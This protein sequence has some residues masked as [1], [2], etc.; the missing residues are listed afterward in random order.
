MLSPNHWTT[1]EFL[2]IIFK[3][4]N[5]KNGPRKGCEADGRIIDVFAVK[6]CEMQSKL[7]HPV[8]GT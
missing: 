1:K 4:G 2:G 5:H 8:F 3:S 7:W 6:P